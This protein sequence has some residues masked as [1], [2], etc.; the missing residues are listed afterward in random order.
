MSQTLPR[1]LTPNEH[2]V[3]VAILSKLDHPERDVLL[4]QLV[5]LSVEPDSI[6]TWTSLSVSDGA[7]PVMDVPEPINVDATVVDDQGEPIGGIVLFLTDGY[8]SDI[9]YFWYEGERPEAFPEPWQI[10]FDRINR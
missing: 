3:L 5:Y 8:L 6:A 7:R 10:V 1:P 9:D 2:D 4:D